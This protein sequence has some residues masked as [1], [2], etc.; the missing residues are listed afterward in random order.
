MEL[1]RCIYSPWVHV[2]GAVV[3]AIWRLVMIPSSAAHEILRIDGL[4]AEQ[5]GAR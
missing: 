2:V 1:H 4:A 5:R 3:L